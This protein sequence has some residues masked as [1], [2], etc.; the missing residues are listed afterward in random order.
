VRYY[1]RGTDPAHDSSHHPGCYR[2][3]RWTGPDSQT[4]GRTVHVSRGKTHKGVVVKLR[5]ASTISGR[6]TSA[7]DGQPVRGRVYLYT[8]SGRFLQ[9]ESTIPFGHSGKYAFVDVPAS[10][11]GYFVCASAPNLKASPKPWLRPECFGQAHWD[12]AAEA[13]SKRAT[14]IRVD[15]HTHR[16]HRDIA[17]HRGGAISGHIAKV[18]NKRVPAQVYVIDDAGHLVA[19]ARSNF[20]T[21][22]W[23]INGLDPART[24][25]VCAE[26]FGG[27][28]RYQPTCYRNAVWYRPWA[29][30]E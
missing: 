2:D 12:G 13:P 14:P 10:R 18:G 29:T 7:A 4:S 6:V 11:S 8:R 15:G 30:R 23:S 16:R 21:T 27:Q 5:R 26:K 22:R 28:P 25:R 20:E 17:L 19:V 24:Y 9:S 3:V 1:A